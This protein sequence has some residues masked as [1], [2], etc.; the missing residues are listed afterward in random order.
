MQAG[1]TRALLKIAG[2][3]VDD[4]ALVDDRVLPSGFVGRMWWA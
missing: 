3:V 4:R 2:D 1:V